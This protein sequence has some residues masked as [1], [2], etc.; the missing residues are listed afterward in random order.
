MGELQTTLFKTFGLILFSL[1]AAS[2]SQFCIDKLRAHLPSPKE[3]ICAENGAFYAYISKYDLPSNNICHTL[4][5]FESDSFV[6]AAQVFKVKKA[7]G[8][9][10]L[11]HGYY[12]HVGMLTHLIEKALS[13]GFN[14]V[15]F[16]LPGHGLSTG[17]RASIE[18]FD[19]YTNAFKSAV[20]IAADE[21]PGPYFAAGHSTGGAVIISY[22]TTYDDSKIETAVL[23]AP[24]IRSS[25][26]RV[27]KIAHFITSP[28]KSK[29][30]RWFRNSSSDT[31]FLRKQQNDP[32]QHQYF[33]MQ[34]ATAYYEWERNI[35]NMKTVSVPITIVQG[36]EDNVVNWRYNIPFLEKRLEKCTT[37]VVEGA[38]HQLFNE[39][40]TI[41]REVLDYFIDALKRGVEK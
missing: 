5:T 14:V 19:H 25:H 23:L 24:L 6:C 32:L 2:S 16:D 9:V 38:K 36:D 35:Q 33:P 34:W 30:P 29:L 41:R 18:S 3:Q 11:V 17:K 39:S 15:A 27:A 31:L 26:F 21:L 4:S 10:I 1:G 20:A 37:K 13:S 12:D 8:T 28:F 7:Q 22:L 40:K